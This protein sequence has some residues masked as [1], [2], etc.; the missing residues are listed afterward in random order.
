LDWEIIEA[1]LDA[2]LAL[3]S[4]ER[5]AALDRIAAENADLRRELESLLQFVDGQDSVLDYSPV[6]PAAGFDAVASIAP[7][8]RIGAY[9][10]LRL[11]GCG[12][13]GE[14]YC[15][16][17]ADGQYQQQVALKLIRREL[18]DQPARFHSER[19]M[20][21]RL[22]H[23]GIARLLDGGVADDGRP[24]MI[25]ELVVGRDLMSWCRERQSPLE[26]RLRLFIDMCSAL[27]YAHRNLVVHRD[28][29]PA[30]VVVT[31]EGAVKLLDFG[32]AKLLAPP[33]AG[34]P[35]D[36]MPTQNA[37]MTPSYA[38][39]EQ[40]T[41]GPITTAT[42]IYALGMLLFELLTG[43]RP[44]NFS[45][46]SLGAGI[47]KVL[48]E[49]PP[50][51]SGFSQARAHPP[52]PPRLLRGDL[53]I[54]AAKALRKEPERRYESVSMLRGDLER[55]QRHE[56]VTAREGARLYAVG[57]FL[58]RYRTLVASLGLA[59]LALLGGTAATLWQANAAR[60]E[61]RRADA[62]RDFLLDMFQH[63]STNNPDGA[64]ARQT[65]AEQLL[66]I[67]AERIRT[68]LT[69]EPQ[70]RGQV[71]AV[72]ADLYD[73]LEKFDKVAEIERTRLAEIERAGNR[74]SSDK[75]AAQALLGRALVMQGDYGAA[76]DELNAALATM[77]EIHDLAS[78]QRAEILL[79]TGRIAYH[80]ATPESLRDALHYA[81]DSLAAYKKS[82]PGN[83][84]RLFALQLAA[85]VAERQGQLP[86]AERLY[87]NFLEQAQLAPFDGV[88]ALRAHGHDDLGSLLL[89]ERRY[90]EAEPQLRQAIEIYAKVEGEKQLNTASDRAYLGQLLIATNRGP[91]GEAL[92]REAL[93][94]LEE[95][96]GADN[97][98]TTAVARLRFARA[99][100]SRGNVPMA[101][102]LLAKN[103]AAFE[104]KNPNDQNYWPE[105]LRS[106][107]EVKL[108]E[109]RFQEADAELTRS[110]HLWPRGGPNDGAKHGINQVLEAR[111]ALD[112]G[113]FDSGT[114]AMLEQVRTAWP[115]TEH[116][117]PAVYVL[118]TLALADA[119]HR[120]SRDG[121][122]ASLTRSLL[123]RILLEPEH[124]ALADW[125]ARTRLL[126][127][128]ALMA[129]GHADA[130]SVQLKRAVELRE[131][132]DDPAS[133][134][135]AETRRALAACRCA[136]AGAVSQL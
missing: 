47:D 94:D 33:G 25:M 7:G 76:Y 101:A 14:V 22:D 66:D 130:A 34:T 87:R 64:A 53:D 126:L 19:Q 23:P 77:N 61:A 62:V 117:L 37:P 102:A 5:P 20:L 119:A 95:T 86:E 82:E 38:A 78:V 9:R 133:V 56:P 57:R 72:L 89:E 112:A 13:M 103:I 30:N 92:L 11:I 44:W 68:G 24:Y 84:D 42:D 125:E 132:F 97:L 104:A 65:T 123:D 74:P 81:Q 21:A 29:K 46:L 113:R 131:R 88:P 70:V 121:E 52:V 116:D 26:E 17:R 41:H 59:L 73:Q 107:A 108:A 99:E 10:V 75:A 2:L 91:A 135:L 28:L 60:L 58:R 105:T 45:E 18:A 90:G 27:E 43:S 55:S 16:E 111:V 63:N 36:E 12:G 93:A 80:R 127:G 4:S 50:L 71:M 69:S 6:G 118:A 3:P 51:M 85:R 124:E 49:V 98:P 79:E 83:P 39:P 115:A 8:T 54:I 136:A 120:Q 96:Q 114:R 128:S 32:I 15:A 122:A 134:W 31:P 40:I 106:D 100:L 35:L 110:D 48:R 129:Q 109:G 1:G 67:G